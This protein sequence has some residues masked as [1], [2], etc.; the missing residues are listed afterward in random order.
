[1]SSKEPD[2]IFRAWFVF[3]R[4]INHKRQGNSMKIQNV[5]RGLVLLVVF[6][7]VLGACEKPVPHNWNAPPVLVQHYTSPGLTPY[8]Y[9]WS[10]M[11]DLVLYA[12]GRVIVTD[13]GHSG[14]KWTRAVNEARLSNSQ[15]CAILYQIEANGFF[16]FK[17]INYH[18]PEDVY[19]FLTTF[20]TVNAWK[21]N[22]VSAYAL[23]YAL[24]PDENTAKETVPSALADTYNLLLEFAPE[25]PTPYQPERIAL[26]I[27]SFEPSQAA[28]LWPLES[29]SLKSMAADRDNY[30]NAEVLLEGQEA[31]DVYALFS[32]DWTISFQ[33]DGVAYEITVRPLLPYE[34][35][36]PEKDLAR[37]PIYQDTPTTPMTCAPQSVN[38]QK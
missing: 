18:E 28:P 7:F 20:I 6:A 3:E 30:G 35:W 32:G 26:L 9:E 12:D 36:N 5:V 17:E 23:N 24:H 15:V 1:M 21:S 33:E 34:I 13:E 22:S 27:T 11:P 4:Q 25:N 29:P 37:V 8:I 2:A 14:V 19:D 10:N 38:T 31:A 16:D